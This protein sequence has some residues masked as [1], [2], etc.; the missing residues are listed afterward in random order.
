MTK[1]QL[2]LKFNGKQVTIQ[3][4][5]NQISIKKSFDKYLLTI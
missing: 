4:L 1:G 5:D 3:Y 2:E